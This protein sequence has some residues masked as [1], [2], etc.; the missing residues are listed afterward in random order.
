MKENRLF[1]DEELTAY[2]DE[3]SNYARIDEI[4]KAL[5]QDSQLRAR[6]EQLGISRQSLVSAFD[7]LLPQAPAIKLSDK[8]L[9]H[10]TFTW[11]SITAAAC[12]I[13]ASFFVGWASRDYSQPSRQNWHD[14]VAAYQALYSPSTLAH[15]Q[16]E[17]SILID[18]LKRISLVLGKDI[19][20]KRLKNSSPLE[21]KRAQVLGYQGQPL[22]QLAFVSPMKAPIALCIIRLNKHGNGELQMS[23]L[24]GMSSV[25]WE[26]DGYAYLLIGGQDP[27]M[28]QHVAEQFVHYL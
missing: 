18:E 1:S 2:L 26:K 11:P 5:A 23:T 28:L 6:V 27:L 20:L 8:H 16:R 19:A 9:G 14:Y 7:S 4:N 25:A 10:S 22:I 24:E 3:E 12:L 17:D 15:I 13:L 21:Y